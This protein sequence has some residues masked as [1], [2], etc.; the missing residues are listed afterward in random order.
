MLTLP[1]SRGAVPA[2]HFARNAHW[3]GSKIAW[4][5][6]TTIYSSEHVRDHAALKSGKYRHLLSDS[7]HDIKNVNIPNRKT[8]FLAATFILIFPI[9]KDEG[10]I[11]NAY[12][13]M[14]HN[15]R[16]ISKVWRS[17]YRPLGCR[18]ACDCPKAAAVAFPLAHGITETQTR[19]FWQDRVY[20]ERMISQHQ[21]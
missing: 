20:P 5:V 7:R 16:R 15:S 9:F 2:N 11:D 18:R 8:Y 12:R 10:R 6:S 3:S 17:A 21:K 14:A 19:S 4:L 13:D 1:S